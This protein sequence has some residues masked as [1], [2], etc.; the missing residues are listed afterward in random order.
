MTVF[1][2]CFVLGLG[3]HLRQTRILSSIVHYQS[4]HFRKSVC[5]MNARRT[6]GVED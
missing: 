2:D 4:R 1:A 3:A 6:A 5:A